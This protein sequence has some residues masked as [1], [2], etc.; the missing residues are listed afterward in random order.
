MPNE[1]YTEGNTFCYFF[2]GDP[3]PL[4]SDYPLQAMA[5]APDRWFWILNNNIPDAAIWRRFEHQKGMAEA[6]VNFDGSDGSINDSFGVDSVQRNGTG[7]YT[8][9]LTYTMP[10]VSFAVLATAVGEGV[11]AS[12]LSQLT[13][14][15]Q[16]STTKFVSGFVVDTD[17]SIVS[18]SVYSG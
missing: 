6:W 1:R 10:N 4:D 16:I 17:P 15:V 8:I 13:T 3:T 9:T 11:I 12:L 14:T 5:F 18:V 7:D 2:P